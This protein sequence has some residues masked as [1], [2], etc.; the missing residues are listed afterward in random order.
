MNA[1]PGSA[2]SSRTGGS[3]A[4]AD[5]GHVDRVLADRLAGARPSLEMKSLRVV[6]M[7][8][9]ALN[10]IA[11]KAVENAWVALPAKAMFSGVQLIRAAVSV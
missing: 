10:G 11:D 2:I 7:T 9:S 1:G 5:L 6:R 8:S 4:A 3:P